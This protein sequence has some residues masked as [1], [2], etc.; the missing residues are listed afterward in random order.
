MN[1]KN[2]PVPFIVGFILLLSL[3]AM[4]YGSR[5]TSGS[6]LVDEVKSLR[7]DLNQLTV[8]VSELDE[9]VIVVDGQVADEHFDWNEF[10]N[11]PKGQ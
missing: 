5:Q 8:I 7:D 3:I 2:N 11:V 4:I 10:H 6:S 1:E 9:P